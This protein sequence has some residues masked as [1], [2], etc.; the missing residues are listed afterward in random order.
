MLG[1]YHASRAASA[2]EESS[3]MRDQTKSVITSLERIPWFSKVGVRDSAKVTVLTSWSEAIAHCTSLEWENFTLEALNQYCESIE[4][5]AP[6]SRWQQW[7]ELVVEM[8]DALGPVIRKATETVATANNLPAAFFEQVHSDF[9]RVCMEVE[10][11]DLR[12]PLFFSGLA[13]YYARGHFPC[14]WSGPYPSGKLIV[15]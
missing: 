14:G 15:F 4:R 3:A 6:A 5:L 9:V 12:P 2:R 1:A 7:N 11:S 13:H 8:N 10:Y